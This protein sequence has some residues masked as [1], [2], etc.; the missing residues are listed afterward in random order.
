MSTTETPSGQTLPEVPAKLSP[1]DTLS[2]LKLFA[3]MSNAEKQA[4][5][6]RHATMVVGNSLIINAI[7]TDVPKPDAFNTLFLNAAGLLL[8]IVWFVMTWVGWGWFYKSMVDATK[9]SNDPMLNPFASYPRLASRRSDTVFLCASAVV[10]I[11]AS[12]YVVGLLPLVHIRA[13][14]PV[15][16]STSA[17]QTGGVFKD[18]ADCPELIVIPAGNFLMGA[19]SPSWLW[20]RN[21]SQQSPNEQPQH[22]VSVK[23]FALGRFEV[24]QQQWFALMGDNPSAHKGDARPVEQ[25]SW[26]DVQVYIQKLNTKTGKR[27]RLPTE[28]EWEYAARAGTTTI[29]SSGDHPAELGRH[30]WFLDNSGM[31]SHPV[32][33]KLP[34]PFGLY[35]MHGNV[36]EWVQD[37]WT[38]N[39]VGA[40]NDGSAAEQAACPL[41]GFRGGGWDS[42]QAGPRSSRRERAP[43]S[44]GREWLGFRLARALP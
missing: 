34:N 6:A 27:Y 31:T 18:C 22:A 43:P 3:D 40:P 36:W 32:G 19:S 15:A 8:C 29:Y 23:S 14:A 12:M 37:C 17:Q 38:E 5:W 11:F 10:L 1:G 13:A 24:T 4:I 21:K 26:Q 2:A 20:W 28:A 25:V 35:D 7:R 9:V 39:Y 33:E 16:G 30:A 42:S 41:R 44:G